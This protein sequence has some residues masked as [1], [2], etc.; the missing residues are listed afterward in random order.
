MSIYVGV[1][2]DQTFESV[3]DLLIKLVLKTNINQNLL[4]SLTIDYFL[5]L[6]FLCFI[7]PC[8]LLQYGI[9]PSHSLA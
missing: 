9:A 4:N 1:V 7:Y 5:L 8:T 2:E 6:T 3:F